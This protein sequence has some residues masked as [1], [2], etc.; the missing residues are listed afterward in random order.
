MRRSRVLELAEGKC[1][2][3]K[4]ENK[5]KANVSKPSRGTG[6][7]QMLRNQILE[8]TE[9]KCIEIKFLEHEEGKCLETKT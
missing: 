3:M 9:G 6:G 1:L 7:R 5:R 2:E 4:S 8:R